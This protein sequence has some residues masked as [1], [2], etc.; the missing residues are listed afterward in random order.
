MYWIPG[1]WRPKSTRSNDIAPG[2]NRDCDLWITHSVD[3]AKPR[4]AIEH[5]QLITSGK[6]WVIPNYH[7]RQVLAVTAPPAQKLGETSYG[8]FL[9]LVNGRYT[10]QSGH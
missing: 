9:P 10:L 3:Y 1:L 6:H 4:N 5:D 7:E 2:V 8:P